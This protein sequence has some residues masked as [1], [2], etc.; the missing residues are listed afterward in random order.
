M[1]GVASILGSG[2]FGAGGAG[3]GAGA[4]APR[5]RRCW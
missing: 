2:A 1:L 5:L 4:G 3:A